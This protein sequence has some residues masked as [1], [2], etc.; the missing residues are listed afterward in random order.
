M[1]SDPAAMTPLLYQFSMQRDG[2]DQERHFY[3]YSLALFRCDLRDLNAEEEA[4]CLFL[5]S[6]WASDYIRIRESRCMT[7]LEAHITSSEFSIYHDD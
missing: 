7:W 6:L 2:V 3:D 5:W 4:G 1:A